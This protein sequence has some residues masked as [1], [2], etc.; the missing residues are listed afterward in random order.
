MSGGKDEAVAVGPFGM[1]GGEAQ[2]LG[3][4]ASAASAIPIGIPGC[5]DLARSTASIAR[6]RRASAISREREGM[7]SGPGS[8]AI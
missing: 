8:E 1:G 3:E 6:T 7:G 5:P 4:S 2:A